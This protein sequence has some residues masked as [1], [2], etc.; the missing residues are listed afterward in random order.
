MILSK[1][2]EAFDTAIILAD[3]CGS[4]AVN[5]TAEHPKEDPESRLQSDILHQY[6]IHPPVSPAWS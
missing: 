4:K 5:E 6:G 2:A 1:M 3:Y